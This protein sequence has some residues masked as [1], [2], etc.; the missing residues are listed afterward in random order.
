MFFLPLCG[1]PK[2]ILRQR[3]CQTPLFFL[4]FVGTCV[5]L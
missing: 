2:Y 5:T 4:I 3:A 1:C